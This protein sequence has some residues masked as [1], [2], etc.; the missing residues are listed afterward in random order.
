MIKLLSLRILLC[1]LVVLVSNTVLHAQDQIEKTWYNQ[2]KTS[3]IQVYKA[4]DGKF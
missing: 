2:E 1:T 3:K 4:K